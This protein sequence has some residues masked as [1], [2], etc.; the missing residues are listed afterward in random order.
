[1]VSFIFFFLYPS[2]ILTLGFTVQRIGRFKPIR[3]PLHP[4]LQEIHLQF[5]LLFHISLCL[6]IRVRNQLS[7]QTYKICIFTFKNFFRNFRISIFPQVM[8]GLLNFFF[9]CLLP[10][11][12]SS[13]LLSSLHQSGNE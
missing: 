13:H 9:Y 5:H 3:C 11:K 1:M 10:D 7:A 8:T 12:I 4:I 2:P 6:P